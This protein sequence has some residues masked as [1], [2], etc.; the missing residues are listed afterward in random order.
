MD[1]QNQDNQ[2]N[3]DT[4]NNANIH[5]TD[6]E[7]PT[8]TSTLSEQPVAVSEQPVVQ[9][10]KK[11]S[12]K[13]WLIPVALL[14]LAAVAAGVFFLLNSDNFKSTTP[15]VVEK[16]VIKIGFLAPL[17]GSDS[18]TIKTARLSTKLAIKEF[19]KEG[20]SVELIES[21]SKCDA[22]GAVPG[23]NELIAKGVVAIIGDFCSG[24]TLAAAPIA[25]KA[26]I[27]MISP[28]STSPKIT[29]S[30]E[31]IFRTIPSDALQGK[32][33]ADLVTSKGLKNLAIMYGNEPY[34]IGLSNSIKTSFEALGGKVQ[35]EPFE[36]GDIKFDAQLARIKTAN[37]D[38]LMIIANDPTSAT[39]ALLAI[40]AASIKAQVFG[41]EAIKSPT[42]LKDAGSAAEGL[43]V[44]STSVG[45]P[46]FR[47]KYKTY[48]QSDADDYASQ[49][50]DA[51]TLLLAAI[52]NGA[53]TGEAIKDAVSKMDIEGVSGHIK[54]D[55]NGDIN[56]NYDV[57]TITNGK[58]VKVN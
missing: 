52:R 54:F 9:G 58:Y 4:E 35:T 34:G 39:A 15:V 7:S 16:K 40:H 37:P 20:I 17:T 45:T 24:A 48:Y 22:A 13:K 26:H 18:Q 8:Q 33:V 53:Y 55:S 21:E 5:V 31:Y 25:N 56:G 14:G 27:P 41:S 32:F 57:Y 6:Y 1:E 11:K 30:G 46:A 43:I 23:V 12:N 47:E 50:Y 51:T 28:S 42:I 10:D 36:N 38:S 29:E 49:A 19:N 2:P 3:S 44:S